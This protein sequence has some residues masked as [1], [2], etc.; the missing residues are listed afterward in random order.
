MMNILTSSTGDGLKLRI[1]SFA[2]LV[3]PLANFYFEKQGIKIAP[4]SVE[5]FIDSAFV[6]AFGIFHVYGWVRAVFKKK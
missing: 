1:T 5:A 3:I 4:E 2:L 6:V